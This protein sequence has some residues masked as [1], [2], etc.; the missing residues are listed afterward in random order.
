MLSLIY[1]IGKE[2]QLAL[3]RPAQVPTCRHW[4]EASPC[5][6]IALLLSQLRTQHWALRKVMSVSGID[7]KAQNNIHSTIASTGQLSWQKPQYMHLVMSMSYLVV[8]LLPSSR[9]SASIVIA[10][11]GHIASH[12]LHAMHR[13]SP[14][15]YLRRACSPRNRGEIGPFS[16]G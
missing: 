9:S 4:L 2:H 3:Q 12:S 16:K 5:C 11:A 6:I 14:V 1:A 10:C 7:P 15:G 8:L 13:S